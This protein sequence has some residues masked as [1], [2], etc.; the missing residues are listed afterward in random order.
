M[1]YPCRQQCDLNFARTR[2]LI[3]YGVFFNYAAF[4]LSVICHL[5]V[6]FCARLLG[7]YNS[8]GHVICHSQKTSLKR[9]LPE[10]RGNFERNPKTPYALSR[11][12]CSNY[13]VCQAHLCFFAKCFLCLPKVLK[14]KIKL[15]KAC[16][17][18]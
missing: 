7:S 18:Y 1:G 9:V 15:A 16:V 17:K 4:I 8:Y 5:L 12:S 13:T 3:G 14:I 2:I 6:L 10:N 11:K